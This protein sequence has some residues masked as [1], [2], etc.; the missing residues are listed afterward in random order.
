MVHLFV[1]NE[2]CERSQIQFEQWKIVLTECK[3]DFK[4]NWVFLAPLPAQRELPNIFEKQIFKRYIWMNTRVSLL[5]GDKNISSITA[6]R[7]AS[8]PNLKLLCCIYFWCI[9]L[10]LLW[11]FLG[12]LVDKPIIFDFT[13]NVGYRFKSEIKAPIFAQFKIRL[14]K[15]YVYKTVYLVRRTQNRAHLVRSPKNDLTKTLLYTFKLLLNRNL[16][17]YQK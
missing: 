3:K 11:K 13:N 1:L 10:V 2:V 12:N 5:S 9:L 6:K 4:R 8:K 14:Q 7:F 17:R 16:L 15:T